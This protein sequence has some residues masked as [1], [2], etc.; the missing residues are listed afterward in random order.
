M[1]KN[2]P[3]TGK[4]LIGVKLYLGKSL[5]SRIQIMYK[6]NQFFSYDGV[7]DFLSELSKTVDVFRLSDWAGQPGVILRHDVDLDVELAVSFAK[8]ELEAGVRSTIFIMTTGETYNPT[9]KPVRNW[10]KWLESNGFEIGLHFDPTVYDTE[11]EVLLTSLAEQEAAVLEAIVGASVR[12]IS[13]H[14]PS[15]SGK[16]PLFS[17]WKN[18]YDPKI[19]GSDIYLS[20]SR[21]MMRHDPYTFFASAQVKTMQLLLHPMH[22]SASGQPYPEPMLAHLRRY[23]DRI[24]DLFSVNDAFVQSGGLELLRNNVK[25]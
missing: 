5:I 6:S 1:H 25:K 24:A 9:S 17:G 4:L 20:D 13:L 8:I 3:Q 16:L 2:Q 22:F 14:N 11:D 23:S 21:M 7:R 18:A 19:F 15:V 10:L 12:S